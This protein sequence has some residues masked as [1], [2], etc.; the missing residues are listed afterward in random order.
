VQ[1]DGVVKLMDFGLARSTASVT[2]T[3]NGC[4]LGTVRY[5]PPEQIEGGEVDY[6]AD[7]FA[8]GCIVY[9]MLTQ[10]NFLQ[11]ET[12]L[13]VLD[14]HHRAL[15]P[16]EVIRADLDSDLYRVLRESLAERPSERVLD[17]DALGRQAGRIDMSVFGAPGD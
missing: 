1:E 8:F 17:L 3:S 7:L 9:E 13:E 15:P 4:L 14:Q 5:M 2:L 10:R 11:G 12:L 16:A 6:R